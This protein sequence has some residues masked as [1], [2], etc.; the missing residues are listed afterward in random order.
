MSRLAIDCLIILWRL[1]ELLRWCE[2]DD[3]TDGLSPQ[4]Y[5]ALREAQNCIRNLCL[6]KLCLPICVIVLESVVCV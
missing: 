2:T 6:S 1:R 3:G 5:M 4:S